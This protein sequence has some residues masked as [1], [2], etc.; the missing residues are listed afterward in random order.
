MRSQPL[1][2][3]A[4]MMLHRRIMHHM[5]TLIGDAGSLG[6]IAR[7]TELLFGSGI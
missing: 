6:S 1:S 5:D 7:Y 3:A 4:A 2:C